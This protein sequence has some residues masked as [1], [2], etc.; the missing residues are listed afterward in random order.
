[1]DPYIASWFRAFLLTTAVEVPLAAVL[2][3]DADRVLARRV[4]RV[5]L[6]SV[7]THPAVWFVFPFL[8]LTYRA[9]VAVSELWAVLAELVYYRLVFWEAGWARAGRAS[10]VANMASFLLGLALQRSGVLR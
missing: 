1:M 10:L 7:L 4:A 5:S 9:Q 6:A 3:R 2:L 8:G